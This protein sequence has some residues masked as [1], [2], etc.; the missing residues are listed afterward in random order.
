MQE[1]TVRCHP[2]GLWPLDCAAEGLRCREGPG[3]VGPCWGLPG[4]RIGLVTSVM[5]LLCRRRGRR[6]I[7]P[8]RQQGCRLAWSQDP[9]VSPHL[10][11]VLLQVW[12]ERSSQVCHSGLPQLLLLPGSWRLS[13]H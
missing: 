13:S 5:G 8:Q 3:R 1:G 11:Q 12:R 7:A 2:P 9:K 6:L 4:R 10:G